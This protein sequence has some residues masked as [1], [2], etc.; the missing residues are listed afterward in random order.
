[1]PSRYSPTHLFAVTAQPNKPASGRM[2]PDR[3]RLVIQFNQRTTMRYSNAVE[4]KKHDLVSQIW[5][6]DV[7][8]PFQL[9]TAMA[10]H[11]RRLTKHALNSQV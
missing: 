2:C 4:H 6:W 7:P 1:M 9:A 10:V 3:R 5:L 11:R 8:S